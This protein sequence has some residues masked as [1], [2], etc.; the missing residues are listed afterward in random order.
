MSL[1]LRDSANFLAAIK[2]FLINMATVIGPTPPKI[3]KL[4]N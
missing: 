1:A 4:I 2:V 3:L